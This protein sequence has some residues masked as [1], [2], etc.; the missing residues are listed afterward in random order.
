MPAQRCIAFQTLG[1][2]LYRLGAGDFGPAQDDLPAGL[3]R[4]FTDGRVLDTLTDAAAVEEGRGHRGSRVYALEALW[5]FE[6][7][8]G[9]SSSRGDDLWPANDTRVYR[10]DSRV[11]SYHTYS[12]LYHTSH[13]L[14]VW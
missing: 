2:I 8:A 10:S 6:K 5:L 14:S 13:L 1:R 11:V 9:S 3:W 7:A 12:V 4:C